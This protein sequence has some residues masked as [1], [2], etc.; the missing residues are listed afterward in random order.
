MVE[1]SL[2]TAERLG[3]VSPGL[4]K[5]PRGPSVDRSIQ[6]RPED[7]G[8][9]RGGGATRHCIWQLHPE[10]ADEKPVFGATA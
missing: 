9:A 1:A 8:R 7:R 3:G 10:G 6:T 4:K 5:D 2:Y